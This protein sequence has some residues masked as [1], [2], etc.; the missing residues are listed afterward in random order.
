MTRI[1]GVSR[2]GYRA[3]VAWP[4]A[5]CAIIRAG[6]GW[7]GM[8]S[9]TIAANRYRRHQQIMVTAPKK[10]PAGEGGLSGTAPARGRRHNDYSTSLAW[11]ARRERSPRASVTWPPWFQPL[12]RSTT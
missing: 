1:T 4:L 8:F 10:K 9:K 7:Q 11:S 3:F 6:A 2:P 5:T 12:K